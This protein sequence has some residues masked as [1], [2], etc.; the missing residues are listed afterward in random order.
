G[1]LLLRQLAA[2][3]HLEVARI[4]DGIGQPTPLGVT[5]IDHRPRVAALEEA[6]AVGEI[7]PAAQ[8]LAAAMALKAMAGQYGAY[9]FLEKLLVPRFGGQRRGR[10]G[11]EKQGTIH[12]GLRRRRWLRVKR[13]A[14]SYFFC[15]ISSM[16][17]RRSLPRT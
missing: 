6:L 2:R 17:T 13:L 10:D 5:G 16:Q 12:G 3:R 9:F 11:A 7:E 1:N 4:A 8:L 15:G 14:E